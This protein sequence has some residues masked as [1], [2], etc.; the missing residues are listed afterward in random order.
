MGMGKASRIA[1]HLAFLRILHKI[2]FGII[3]AKLV[4]VYIARNICIN[5]KWVTLVTNPSQKIEILTS[6][7]YLQ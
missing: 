4:F 1:F 2:F 6:Y 3:S 5:A 7:C